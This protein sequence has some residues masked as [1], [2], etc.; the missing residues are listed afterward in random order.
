MTN[1]SQSL[2]FALA[3]VAL[4]S[5]VATAFKI[6][7]KYQSPDDL[8]F[9]S[10]FFSTVFFAI[11]VLFSNNTKF[12]LPKII[13]LVKSAVAGLINPFLYYFVLFISYDLL[14]AQL[15]QPLNYSWVIVISILS[16]VVLKQK[17]RTVE[18]VSLGIGLLGVAI[19]ASGGKLVYD[20]NYS[21]IGIVLAIGS[22]LLWGA[23]WILNL[24][25]NRSAEIKLFWSFLFGSIYILL[26][27]GFSIPTL[28]TEMLLSSAYVGLFEMGVTFVLWMKA[29][30]LSQNNAQIGMVIYLSPFLS[31]VMIHFVLGES[32]QFTSILGLLLIIGGVFLRRI[33][34]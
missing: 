22:S 18:L 5:T 15:A 6:A 31:L 33:I 7:L 10:V 8:L 21:T 23:Y 1:K 17:I 24:K 19:I 29:L 13:D 16:I 27:R 14:P 34:K 2:L 3:A 28:S 12:K 9:F 32:I 20:T 30:Q 4:W 26:Y 25:D 11:Y